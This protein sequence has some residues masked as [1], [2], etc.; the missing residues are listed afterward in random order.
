MT[1]LGGEYEDSRATAAG[2]L[3]VVGTDASVADP[4]LLK[5][6]RSKQTSGNMRMMAVVAWL[7]FMPPDKPVGPLLLDAFKSLDLAKEDEDAG[8]NTAGAE[9]SAVYI[10]LV[11]IS[12]GRTIIEVPTLAELTNSKYRRGYRATAIIVLAEL[13][14]DATA[15]IPELRKLLTDED[16]LIRQAA[17]QAI[18]HIAG[19]ATELPAILKAMNLDEKERVE[20]EQSISE[21]F[22]EQQR[23]RKTLRDSGSEILEFVIRQ[24]RFGQPFFQRQAIHFLKEIGPAATVAIPELLAATKSDDKATREAAISALKRVDISVSP[25]AE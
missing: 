16:S 4:A 5:I 20:F 13:G 8:D 7:H 24:L 18:I 3:G 19:N 15:A 21:F 10:A 25:K 17:G 2:L 23:T 14:S 12:S 9:I 22:E 6:I 1:L 11:L